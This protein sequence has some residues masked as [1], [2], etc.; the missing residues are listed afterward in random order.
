MFENLDSIEEWDRIRALS[1]THNVESL[2]TV[3]LWHALSLQT[4][5]NISVDTDEKS[6]NIPNFIV[7]S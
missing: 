7:H 5:G 2:S 6:K 3:F 1:F 4:T